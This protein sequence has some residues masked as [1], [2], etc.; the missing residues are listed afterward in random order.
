MARLNTL[1]YPEF[2]PAVLD[3][4]RGL[5]TPDRR[6]ALTSHEGLAEIMRLGVADGSALS[7]EVITAVAM[8]FGY[9]T[10][11]WPWP[12]RGSRL[13]WSGF[14]EIAGLLPDLQVPVRIVYGAQDRLLPDVADTMARLRADLPQA[15]ITALPACGH[16]VQ[17]DAPDEVGDLLA[18]FFAGQQ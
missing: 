7:Q 18:R 12:P 13:R 2:S 1:V 8:P 4:A 10:L 17:E 14:A 11:D 9:R 15:Q 3:F 5:L 16:F 6:D